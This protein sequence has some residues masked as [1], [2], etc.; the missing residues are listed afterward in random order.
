[1]NDDEDDDDN[2]ANGDGDD[3]D[4]DKEENNKTKSE[5]VEMNKYTHKIEFILLWLS[6]CLIK[7]FKSS[8]H[9]FAPIIGAY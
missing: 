1:M 7:V 6:I 9:V 4:D 8:F 5:K 3:N 2:D